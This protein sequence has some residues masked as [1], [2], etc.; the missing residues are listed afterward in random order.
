MC[1]LAQGHALLRR[2]S[3][4][5]DS[6]GPLVWY[7]NDTQQYYEYGIVSWGARCADRDYAG[8]SFTC[9][10]W[11]VKLPKAS[12]RELLPTAIGLR[13]L[14]EALLRV[15]RRCDDFSTV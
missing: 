1:F 7:H 9:T 8:A 6:G 14:P 12:T 4:Q 13:R 3:L 15:G 5:G 11:N 10:C 2:L